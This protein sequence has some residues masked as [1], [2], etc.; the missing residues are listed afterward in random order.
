MAH[1]GISRSSRRPNTVRSLT[2]ITS[3]RATKSIANSLLSRRVT[4]VSGHGYLLS[5]EAK[6]VHSVSSHIGQY[7]RVKKMVTVVHTVPPSNRTVERLANTLL[8]YS[9][10]TAA[11]F[12]FE[13]KLPKFG[14]RT[15]DSLKSGFS[16]ISWRLPSSTN[17][18]PPQC[19]HTALV[20]INHS[21]F[22]NCL[23]SSP[24]IVP[25]HAKRAQ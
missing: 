21:L 16:H 6:F 15:V 18:F 17:A 3:V 4:L 25:W 24:F 9:P 23:P 8:L 1:R 14:T 7:P 12:D 20:R 11:I 19:L 10:H 13:Q 2:S 5:N 22:L